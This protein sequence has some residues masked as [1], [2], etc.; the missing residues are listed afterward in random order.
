M[1]QSVG[2]VVRGFIFLTLFMLVTIFLPAGTWNYWQAWVY[3][4]VFFAATT[5]VTVYLWRHD[6]ALMVRRSSA[7]PTA[8]KDPAQRRIQTFTSLCFLALMVVPGLDHRWGWSQVPPIWVLVGDVLV[9]I[10]FAAIHEVYRENTFA[11]AT[12]E[13]AEGQTVISTGLY[14]VVR[15]PMYSGGLI[16]ILG[17]PLA[18]GSWWGLIVWLFLVLGIVWRLSDEER[19]LV[20]D[21]PGYDAYRGRVRYRLIPGIW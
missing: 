20:R 2:L 19:V 7:G 10:G 16:M 21:L 1:D 12:V 17:T 13:V 15:H 6:K 3:L 5:W 11:S 18:L 8:E 9:V 4:A 14:G